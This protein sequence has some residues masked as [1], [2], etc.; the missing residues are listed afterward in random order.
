MGFSCWRDFEHPSCESKRDGAVVV[1]LDRPG[2]LKGANVRAHR[3]MF[4][5]NPAIDGD[6]HS[7][8]LRDSLRTS[9][10]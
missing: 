7:I 1:T 4:E 8:V 3:E 9:D 10:Q 5:M 6:H 2:A